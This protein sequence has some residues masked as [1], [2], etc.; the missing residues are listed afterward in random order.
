M[1]EAA[2]IYVIGIINNRQLAFKAS[3]VIDKLLEKYKI[4]W[5]LAEIHHSSFL[6]RRRY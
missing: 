6:Q 2:K 1:V 3:A 4:K 5:E